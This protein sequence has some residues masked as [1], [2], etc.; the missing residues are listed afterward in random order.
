MSFATSPNDELE[1]APR[2]MPVQ[3]ATLL[4]DMAGAAV[5]L[6]QHNPF[7]QGDPGGERTLRAKA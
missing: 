6:A 3:S 7:G 1:A 4:G 2:V 5:H